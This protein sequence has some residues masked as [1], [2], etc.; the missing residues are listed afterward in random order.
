MDALEDTPEAATLASR[1]SGRSC[2]V[3]DFEPGL[4]LFFDLSVPLDFER[5]S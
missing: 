5:P 2:S 3:D 1:A 4:S